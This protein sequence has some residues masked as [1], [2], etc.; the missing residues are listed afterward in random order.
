MQITLTEQLI[1]AVMTAAATLGVGWLTLRGVV[2]KA[3][4]EE[5]ATN[6]TAR[7]ELERLLM[8]RIDQLQQHISALEAR[9]TAKDARIQELETRV[10]ELEAENAR[11]KAELERICKE[12]GGKRGIGISKGDS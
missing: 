1:M 12:R 8:A 4:Q 6:A 5:M 11:L 7:V 3:Q 10:D 2:R 9:I